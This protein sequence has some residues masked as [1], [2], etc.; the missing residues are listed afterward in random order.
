MVDVPKPKAETAFTALA[1]KSL[2]KRT[3]VLESKHW[4]GHPGALAS[5]G[6]RHLS[7]RIE[8]AVS[9]T[10]SQLA[11]IARW[12]VAVPYMLVLDRTHLE[13]VFGWIEQTRIFVSTVP[14]LVGQVG[15]G[16]GLGQFRIFLEQANFGIVRIRRRAGRLATAKHHC[17]GE[18]RDTGLHAVG[19][20]H[21]FKALKRVLE[22]CGAGADHVHT[23]YRAYDRATPRS[24]Q[25]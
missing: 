3:T 12:H 21:F 17:V 23:G 14:R 2:Y 11:L 15:V 9:K 18:L 5:A 19:G 25:A 22:R 20:R 4:A 13:Y 7:I 16:C 6:A 1:G 10:P 24:T 8:S